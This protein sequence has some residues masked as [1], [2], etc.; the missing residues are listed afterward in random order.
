M[1]G[2]VCG[3]TAADLDSFVPARPCSAVVRAFTV[4]KQERNV[5][6]LRSRVM[7]VEMVRWPTDEHRLDEIRAA[8]SAGVEAHRKRLGRGWALVATDRS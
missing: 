6:C 2:T 7:D 4:A 5:R 8:L 1:A 3:G